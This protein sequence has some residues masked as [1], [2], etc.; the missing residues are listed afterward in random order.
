MGDLIG[1]I[2]RRIEFY[3]E[4]SFVGSGLGFVETRQTENLDLLE[5]ILAQWPRDVQGDCKTGH[6]AGTLRTMVTDL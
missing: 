2:Q 5:M 6:T 1:R 3:S 4:K